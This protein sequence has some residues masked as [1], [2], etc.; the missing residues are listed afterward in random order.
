MK[1]L[2]WRCDDFG[3]ATG[4]NEAF[5]RI[6]RL[7]LPVN[8][9]ILTCA[10]EA[11]TR[12]DELAKFSPTIC[13]GIHAA[14]NSEWSTLKWGPVREASRK[15]KLVDANGHFHPDYEIL[16]KQPPELIA[17]E[18]EAQVERALGW[19]IPFSYLDEHMGFAWIPGV[20]PLLAK[21][22]AAHGLIYEREV[23]GLPAVKAS[24]S[25]LVE[26]IAQ[27]LDAVSDEKPRLAIFHPAV[28]DASTRK[29]YAGQEPS[30]A[31]S[32]ERQ[33]ELDTLT[34]ADWRSLVSEGGVQL[35]TYRDL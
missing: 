12:L 6:A 17:A 16:A 21:I 33:K 35:I 15:T 4:A 23:P 20:A 22:A 34:S 26:H 30:D 18:V 5:L 11:R 27:Q 2:L 28:D 9:S 13:L 7:G 19:G 31:T 10:P 24:N 8:C 14:V 25:N 3:S 29:F 32:R 1:K